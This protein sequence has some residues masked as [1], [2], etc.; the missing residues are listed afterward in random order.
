ML[1]YL[2][3]HKDNWMFDLQC[4]ILFEH[5]LELGVLNRSILI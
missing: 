2:R 1:P 3:G 5:W 4:A